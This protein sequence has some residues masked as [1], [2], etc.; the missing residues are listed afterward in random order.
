MA[1]CPSCC[2]KYVGFGGDDARK[3]VVLTCLCVFCKACA[4]QEEVKAQQQ[5]PASG[6][7]GKREKGRKG[8]RR[9]RRRKQ[10]TNQHLA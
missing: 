3:P 6:G 8:K 10:S 1:A 7:G 9:G 5:Q 4:L 2:K